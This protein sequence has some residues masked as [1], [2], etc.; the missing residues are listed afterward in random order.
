MPNP[1]SLLGLRNPK[2]LLQPGRWGQ[3]N[4]LNLLELEDRLALSVNIPLSGTGWT[5]IGPLPIAGETSTPGDLNATGRHTGVAAHPTNSKIVYISSAGGG[6]AKTEDGGTTW[7]EVTDRIPGLTDE[8]RN[9]NFGSVAVS[10]V[11][12]KATNDYNVYAGGGEANFSGDSYAG[13]GILKSSDG[14][15]SWTLIEGP[16]G[17]FID[18]ATP[19]IVVIANPQN[20]T[21]EIV[22]AAVNN[23]VVYASPINANGV[24]RSDDSGAT[25]VRITDDLQTGINQV[26]LQ[27]LGTV[28][29]FAVDPI[30]PEVAYV[31]IGFPSN[32]DAVGNNYDR[33]GI[34]KT[35]NSRSNDPDW[36]VAFGGNGTFVPG[37]KL[38]RIEIAVAPSRPSVV[39]ALVSDSRTQKA[40]GVFRTQDAGTN[41]RQF[42]NV[43]DFLSSQAFYNVGI[44]V[45]PDNESRL[46]LSGTGYAPDNTMIIGTND[47]LNPDPSKVTWSNLVSKTDTAPNPH[48]DTHFLN[49]DAE[50]RLLVSTDGGLFRT[51]LTDSGLAITADAWVSMNGVAGPNALNTATFIGIALH[52]N[53]AEDAIGG[54]QDNGVVQFF[55]NGDQTNPTPWGWNMVLGGDGGEVSYDFLNPNNMV[56]TAPYDFARVSYSNDKGKTWTAVA[57]PNAAAGGNFYPTIFRDP[58]NTNRILQGEDVLNVSTNNGKSFSQLGPSV[59]WITGIPQ[60]FKPSAVT[61][62]AVSR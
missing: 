53:S 12:N 3:S 30:N 34:Y 43:P 15:K 59:P 41:W 10:P 21:Q 49:F 32:V 60:P 40:L 4:P 33:N 17:A 42:T 51:S 2:S 56:M 39:Y 16:G 57:V 54:L 23:N 28:T 14:G 48:V 47:A 26:D 1:N 22:Y 58:S 9:L 44:A 35:T 25:W 11:L 37:S 52:P 29:D 62:I 24:Y 55:D 6:I 7:K 8:Q 31:A 36:S 46:F 27:F 19:K 5:E 18:M 45:D 61:D 38:G 13:K 50:Q 20:P